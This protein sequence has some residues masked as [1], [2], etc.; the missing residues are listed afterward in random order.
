MTASETES[1]TVQVDG[2]ETRSA[3][4][5]EARRSPPAGEKDAATEEDL[6]AD[7]AVADPNIVD[8]DGPNDPA[9]PRNWSKRR[10]MLNVMLVSLSVLYSYVWIRSF[11]IW[12]KSGHL[13]I[14]KTKY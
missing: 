1:G 9:N 11:P 12:A 3:D 4:G 7:D 5:D 14:A 2:H 13:A 8:W 10:K 6:S